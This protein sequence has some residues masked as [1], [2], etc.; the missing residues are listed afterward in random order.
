MSRSEKV[1][2]QL[3]TT[4]II[5]IFTIHFNGAGQKVANFSKIFKKRIFRKWP[6]QW[7]HLGDNMKFVK[8]T[9]RGRFSTGVIFLFEISWEC[10][11][12]FEEKTVR[13]SWKSSDKDNT[14]KIGLHTFSRM[15]H[16]Y[17]YSHLNVN[18]KI[19][20]WIKH[21]KWRYRLFTKV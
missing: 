17:F 14:L 2:G 21:L 1:L 10:D 13:L 8:F 15:N 16:R 9:N 7:T 12:I 11:I 20:L 3:H 6:Q 19:V 5:P 18:F 4:T